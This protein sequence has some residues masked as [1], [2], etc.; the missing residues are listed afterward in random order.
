MIKICY[1]YNNAIGKRL[2]FAS[3]IFVIIFRGHQ[4]QY[5][6]EK[7][8]CDFNMLKYLPYNAKRKFFEAQGFCALHYI[9][10]IVAKNICEN[11]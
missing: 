6:R 4:L 10:D 11:Y 7:N 3:L 8:E 2:W 1:C 5:F 9:V